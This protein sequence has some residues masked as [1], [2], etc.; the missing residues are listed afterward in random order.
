MV[1]QTSVIKIDG[2]D[3]ASIVIRQTELAVIESRRKLIDPGTALREKILVRPCYAE[4]C[5]L[6]RNARSDY[7]DIN[8][9]LGSQ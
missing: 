8:T 1:E 6:I 4:Y 5:P 3:H 7:P 2:S 9:T